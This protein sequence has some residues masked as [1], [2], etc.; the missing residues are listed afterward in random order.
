MASSSVLSYLSKLK[1]KNIAIIYTFQNEKSPGFG[2]YDYWGTGVVADWMKAVELL[3]CVPYILDVRTFGHKALNNSLPPIDFIINLNA[4]NESISTLGLVP[5]IA[6]FLGI[7]CIPN[8]TL[9]TV[10]SESKSLS[11]MIAMSHG[12]NIPR[13]LNRDERGGISRP[14]NYGSSRGITRVFD[15]IAPQNCLYQEFI[16]GFD[17]T[18]PL[19]FNPEK[20]ALDILPGIIYIPKN[21]DLSWYLSEDEKQKLKNYTKVVARLDCEVTPILVQLAEI[22]Q[23]KTLCRIDTR[24]SCDNFEDLENILSSSVPLSRLNFLEINA[25]PTITEGINFCNSVDGL[26]IKDGLGIVYNNIKSTIP[27]MSNTA[28]VLFCALCALL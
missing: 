15:V 17:F 19:L 9:A 13:K 11:N 27:E 16:K 10:V 23:I 5:S 6:G 14:D 18:I 25:M 28:F 8:E 4:G 1:R 20:K 22:Y 24:I 21:R 2:H 12:I 7:P 26:N 3:G